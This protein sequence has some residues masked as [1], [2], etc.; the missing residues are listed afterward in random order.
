M[1][2]QLIQSWSILSQPTAD[3]TRYVKMTLKLVILLRSEEVHLYTYYHNL[4]YD[5]RVTKVIYHY[6]QEWKTT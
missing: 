1:E 3:P 6:K 4:V 5:T 2:T